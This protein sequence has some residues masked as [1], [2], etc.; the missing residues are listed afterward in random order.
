MPAKVIS[1]R[2]YAEAAGGR[3]SILE[4]A[5]HDYIRWAVGGP[6]ANSYSGPYRVVERR[7][8]TL[9]IQM[10]DSQEW[11]S[12]DRAKPHAGRSP[13]VAQPPKRGRL[14]GSSSGV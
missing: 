8:K 3:P 4:G 14:L 1:D 6:L 13:Q 12:A 11:V 7:Q 5:S 9:L 10:G 2:S